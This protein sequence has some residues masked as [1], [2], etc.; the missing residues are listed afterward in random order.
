[1]GISPV[2]S[3]RMPHVTSKMRHTTTPTKARN[4][5]HPTTKVVNNPKELRA[6]TLMGRVVDPEKLPTIKCLRVRHHRS[7]GHLSSVTPVTFASGANSPDIDCSPASRRGPGFDPLLQPP[8]CTEPCQLR[9]MRVTTVG[10]GHRYAN[11]LMSAN[12]QCCVCAVSQRT[13]TSAAPSYSG[14]SISAE[15]LRGVL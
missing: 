9:T 12:R 5:A 4:T 14:A 10:S 6:K 15:S 8:A 3:H 7:P 13:D 11:T 2:S 1:V